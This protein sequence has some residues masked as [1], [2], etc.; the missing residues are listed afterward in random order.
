MQD[1]PDQLP[2]ALEP[3]G[4]A[5]SSIGDLIAYSRA[6]LRGLRGHDGFLR[7]AS[8]RELH[9]P[10]AG[11]TRPVDPF[12]PPVGVAAGWLVF[13]LPDG[14]RVGWHNGSAGGFFA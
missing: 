10:E 1:D 6:H 2:P 8:V 13:A 14:H 9:R 11:P 5:R 4:A 12:G 3:A 7:A